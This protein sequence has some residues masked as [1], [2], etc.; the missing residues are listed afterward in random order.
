MGLTTI[1]ICPVCG[2]SDPEIFIEIPQVPVHCNLLWQSSEEAI[3]A[4]RGDI[5]L[6]FCKACGHV[7]NVAFDPD[8]VEYTQEY[9]NSLHFSPRFGSYIK[10]LAARLIEQYDLHDKDIVEI[11]CGSGEFLSLLCEKGGNRGVGFDPSHA[12]DWDSTGTNKRIT[13]IRDFY[14]ERYASYQP[15]LICC[16]HVLEH[17][18]F[19]CE[20]LLTVR[21]IIGNRFSTIVFFEVPNVMFTLKDLGIWDLIYEHCSYFCFS[22][23]SYVFTDCGFKVVNLTEAFHGQFLCIEALPL[24]KLSHVEKSHWDNLERMQDYVNVFSERYYVK[25]KEWERNLETM[26]RQRQSAV[27]WGGGSKGV[28]FLNTLKRQDYIQYVVDINER[29]HGMYVAGTGQKI[30]PPAFLKEYHP[31]I[32]I[33]MNPTYFQEIQQLVKDMNISTE[34]ISV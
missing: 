21:R 9:E 26:K 12:A 18:Q 17:I 7:F 33:V 24:E 34:Y 19:P 14:S 32:V 1:Y 30:V 16:R 23:L 4:P 29:K 6:A 11:G 10:A 5:R 22:S 2:S 28:T 31:D 20:L 8:R 27:V 15:D 25:V 13:F 3:H